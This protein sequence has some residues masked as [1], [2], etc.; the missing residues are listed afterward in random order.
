M[1][2]K[3]LSHC[4]RDSALSQQGCKRLPQ[5]VELE[6]RKSRLGA[7]SIPLLP[8]KPVREQ[9]LM[10]IEEMVGVTEKKTEC[11][12]NLQLGCAKQRAKKQSSR[13]ARTTMIVYREWVILL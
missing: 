6:I 1:L 5:V 10:P 4:G 11:T 13:E 7:C 12:K 2:Q 8:R 3:P 9:L